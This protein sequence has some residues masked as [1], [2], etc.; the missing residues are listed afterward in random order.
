MLLKKKL[1]LASASHRRKNLLTQIG[2]TFEVRASEIDE[3]FDLGRSVQENVQSL[4]LQKAFAVAEAGDD[5]IIV[6]A[7]TV[8]VL[9]SEILT[10]PRDEQEARLMLAK[11]SGREHIVHTGIALVDLPT[12][13]TVAGVE[14]TKVKFRTL[15]SEEI[16]EY[17]KSG[18]PMDKAGAY[19]IQDDYGAVFVERIDGCFYNVVGFP[20]A[21]FY[22]AVSEFQKLLGLV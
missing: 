19:G 6:G 5:A 15:S 4:A 16:S 18:S 14:T 20:L 21:R 8:V 12:R 7:D 22:V 11:L 3:Q 9:G 2:L 10:K 1:I 17:V 13:R